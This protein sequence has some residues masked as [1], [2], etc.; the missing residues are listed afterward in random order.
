MIPALNNT[1]RYIPAQQPAD[2]GMQWSPTPQSLCDLAVADGF[3][4]YPTLHLNES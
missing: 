4:W 2:C 1:L 3:R